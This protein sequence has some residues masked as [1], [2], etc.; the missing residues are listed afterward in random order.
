MDLDCCT[1]FDEDTTVTIS[2]GGTAT[3]TDDYT[4]TIA[5]VTIPASTATG[6]TAAAVSITPVEDTIVEGDE[7][8]VGQRQPHRLCGLSGHH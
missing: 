6:S 7:S 5:N 1:T 3:G 2:L 8:I 4:A